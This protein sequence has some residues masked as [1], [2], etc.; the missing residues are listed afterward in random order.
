M[1]SHYNLVL[2]AASAPVINAQCIQVNG[3]PPTPTHIASILFLC[4]LTCLHSGLLVHFFAFT[5]CLASPM[6]VWGLY[7]TDLKK[8]TDVFDLVNPVYRLGHCDR[9]TSNRRYPILSLIHI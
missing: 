4:L 1:M 2:T 6:R 7:M 3:G 9:A 8:P 5:P